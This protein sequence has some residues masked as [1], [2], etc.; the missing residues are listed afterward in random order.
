MLLFIYIV[1]KELTL[2]ALGMVLSAISKIYLLELELNYFEGKC[3]PL[4]YLFGVQ[5]SDYGAST[6]ASYKA[7][8]TCPKIFAITV[9]DCSTVLSKR[10]MY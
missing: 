6:I 8:F 3:A 4:H 9:L 5:F 7:L 1:H 2:I 10:H